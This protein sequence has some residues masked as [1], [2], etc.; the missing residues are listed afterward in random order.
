MGDLLSFVTPGDLARG[1]LLHLCWRQTI[2]F[3]L[4][5]PLRESTP[6]RADPDMAVAVTAGLARQV[7]GR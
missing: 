4:D 6:V 1:V 5:Q 3:D 2:V 7:S